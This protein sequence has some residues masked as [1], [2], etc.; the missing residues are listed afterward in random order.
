[1]P[2]TARGAVL[3]C[4]TFARTGGR[5]FSPADIGLASELAAFAAVCIDNARLY[6]QERR[7]AFVLQ[8]GL[9]PAEPH[10]PEAVD[11]AYR[12]LPVGASIVGGD[13]H[14]VVSLPA[15]RAALIVGDA[16]RSSSRASAREDAQP[17]ARDPGPGS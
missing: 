11:V 16:I 2:L 9:L 7:T 4:A 8:Q 5:G 14:D 17:P 3:G 15:G 12:Y 10:T 13:W 6:H 1:M